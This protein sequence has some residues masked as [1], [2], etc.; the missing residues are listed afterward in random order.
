VR[1][2]GNLQRPPRAFRAARQARDLARQGLQDE[3]PRN[4]SKAWRQA[5][6]QRI[7]P[8]IKRLGINKSLY[9]WRHC[10]QTRMRGALM[11]KDERDF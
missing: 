5:R 9:S 10:F 4:M 8:G 6:R 7:N 1:Q 3:V 11:S 2:Q